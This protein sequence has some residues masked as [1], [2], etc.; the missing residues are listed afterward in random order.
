MSTLKV[1]KIEN[2]KIVTFENADFINEEDMMN[3]V[4]IFKETTEKREKLIF[5]LENGYVKNK[6]IGLRFHKMGVK[7]EQK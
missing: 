7:F 2:Q 1:S 5:K 6:L 3:L 4:G